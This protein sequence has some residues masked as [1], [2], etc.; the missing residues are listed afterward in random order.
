MKKKLLSLL[1][2]LTACTTV[3]AQF[4]QVGDLK[5][6]SLYCEDGSHQVAVVGSDWNSSIIAIPAFIVYN[7]RTFRVTEIAA[8]AFR[9]HPNLTSIT[10]P[11]SVRTIG[12]NAFECCLNLTSVSLGNGVQTIESKAFRQCRKLPLIVVPNS[13]DSIDEWAFEDVANVVY[14]GPSTF[15]SPW[16]ARYVNGYTEDWLVYADT[17]KTRL[18]TCAMYAPGAIEIPEGVITIGDNAFRECDSITSIIVPTSCREIENQAF[19]LCRS[20]VSVSL[21]DNIDSI[22]TYAFQQCY[23]L[24][25]V[26]IPNSITC[27]KES[28]FSYCSFSNIT[29]PDNVTSIGQGAFGYCSN[30]TQIIIPNGVTSIETYTF[31]GCSSL[32][33]ITMG[34]SVMSVGYGAIQ[35]C[36]NLQ[37]IT[38]YTIDP[39]SID[40]W[41]TGLNNVPVANVALYVPAAGVTAYQAHSVWGQFD[42][43]AIAGTNLQ[44]TQAVNDATQTQKL[45]DNGHLYFLLPDGTHYDATGKKV[46]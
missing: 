25:H 26:N 40:V 24:T 3:S 5:Y 20:L 16:G 36:S 15:H 39:P 33:S 21:P 34:D 43:R 4:F 12:N 6:D 35:E 45:F 29:I 10:I 17:S 44:S 13:V 41:P 31:L 19:A 37:E 32:T 22:G 28:T 30:L 8:T 42:V 18:T 9:C 11:N 14:H 2:I 38:C 1:L 46:E 23:S 7:S 27:I